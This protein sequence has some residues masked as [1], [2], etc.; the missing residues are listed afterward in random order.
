MTKDNPL[1]DH[2]SHLL[3]VLQINVLDQDAPNESQNHDT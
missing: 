2:T 3:E 1:E